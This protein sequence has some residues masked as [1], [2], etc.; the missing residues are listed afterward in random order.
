MKMKNSPLPQVTINKKVMRYILLLLFACSTLL[1]F[2]QHQR[3]DK[4]FVRKYVKEVLKTSDLKACA[5][6]YLDIHESYYE[7]DADTNLVVKWYVRQNKLMKYRIKKNNGKYKILSHIKHSDH[8]LIKSYKLKVDDY[9]GVFY[10]ISK[11]EA[12]G[13]VIVKD[14]K[15]ITNFCLYLV[16]TQFNYPWYTNIRK[17]DHVIDE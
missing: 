4:A 17:E 13:F 5:E 7:T 2:A 15:I 16:G 14:E 3:K 10:I 12:V 8:P 1:S 9:S 6:K 11:D